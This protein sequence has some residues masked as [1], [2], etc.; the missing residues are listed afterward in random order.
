MT[1]FVNMAAWQNAPGQALVIRPGS[2]PA[3]RPGEILVRNA[4]IAINPLDW[5]LQENALLPWLDYPA[6]LGSDIAG[7]V[8]AIGADVTRFKVGDRV[9][10]QAVGTTV[11]DPA[12]GAFQTHTV[13]PE[14]MTSPI[15]DTMA[16][17]EAAVLPLGLGTAACGLYQQVHLGLAPPSLAP[18]ATEQVVLI[19]GASSSVGC[20]AVQLAVASGYQC[21][22]VAATRHTGLLKRL[23]ATLVLD[24]RQP[25]V[26]E[27]VVHALRGKTLA[28]A[29]HATGN[30]AD[31]FAVVARSE[32]SRI[33]AT[34]LP[35]SE[36]VPECVEARQIFGTSLK[37]DGVGAMIYR[38][39]LPE[40]LAVGCYRPAPSPRIAGHGLESLQTALEMQK[41]GVS[42]EKV[43]VSMS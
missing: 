2:S 3:L 26:I 18:I 40:A 12:Q 1:E 6:V 27:D 7:E 38:D 17:T 24:H 15:P 37:D 4:A 14:N 42:G 35:P 30:M 34:T 31:S 5:L 21:V 16:F 29:L 32:G 36:D 25:S 20:N 10:G 33:V 9:L 11:N 43:V 22:A 41:A 8:A 13:V 28:G 23:G 19:W 39:F